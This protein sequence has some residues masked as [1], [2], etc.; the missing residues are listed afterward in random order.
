MTLM[1]LFMQYCLTNLDLLIGAPSKNSTYSSPFLLLVV[2]LRNFI[3]SFSVRYLGYKYQYKSLSLLIPAIV[4]AFIYF[5]FG[6]IG[7]ITYFL[8]VINAYLI[9]SDPNNKLSS[10]CITSIHFCKHSLTSFQFFLCVS[11][12]TCGRY[13]FNIG[14]FCLHDF[15]HN[16]SNLILIPQIPGRNACIRMSTDVIVN[17]FH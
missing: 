10:T 12:Y 14:F 13:F 7:I 15:F 6:F 16:S 8:R 3:V 1:L 9:I 17:P 4:V 2:F 11:N 5:C